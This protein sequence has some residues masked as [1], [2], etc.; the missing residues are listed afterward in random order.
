M[1]F[2]SAASL[3][4]GVAGLGMSAASAAGAFSSSVDQS[5]PTMAEQQ[6]AKDARATYNLGRKIQVPLDA[7]A[8]KDLAYLGS[9]QALDTA[10]GDGVNQFWRQLGPLGQQLAPYA[11]ASGGPGSGRW[12]NQLGQGA[13]SLSN[14]LQAANVQGRIG[15]LNNYLARQGQ[16]LG[17][18][19]NDLEVGLGTMTSGGAMAAQNQAATRQM[20]IQNNIA[21]NQAMGQIGGTMVGLGMSGVS[22]GL[23]GAAGAAGNAGG[24]FG[25]ISSG[26][27]LY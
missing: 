16:F 23:G 5:G 4:V 13:A 10:G 6:A 1:T 24:G 20:Q 14:G 2:F 8:R 7:M 21:A 9:G 19:T 17:R 26:N 18:R 11:N 15:G 3:A 22:A 27:G 12:M 25:W